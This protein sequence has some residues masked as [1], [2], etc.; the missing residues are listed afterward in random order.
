MM[1]EYDT[2]IGYDD[3]F[4]LYVIYEYWKVYNNSYK[5]NK[6]MIVIVWI[7]I[8]TIC[9]KFFNIKNINYYHDKNITIRKLLNNDQF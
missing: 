2:C 5:H 4:I 3:T 7:Q 8:K 9:N 1:H 6:Y